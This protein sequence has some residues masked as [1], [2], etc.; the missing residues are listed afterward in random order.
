MNVN[1]NLDIA[2]LKAEFKEKKLVR[3]DNFLSIETA[4]DAYLFYNSQM[5]DDWWYLSTFPLRPGVNQVTDNVR[6]MQDKD[7]RS[8]NS[9]KKALADEYFQEDLYSYSFKRTIGDHDGACDCFECGFRKFLDSLEVINVIN[10]ITDYGIIEA[11]T[12]FA[13]KYEE[14]DFL[15]PHHDGPN[16]KIGFVYNLTPGWRPEWGGLLNTLSR[17]KMTILDSLVPKYN[18]LTLFDSST[19][20]GYPHYVTQVVRK[21]VK[22]LSY[23]GWYR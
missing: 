4:K 6:E 10:D 5:P 18:T 1:P 14:G 21:N 8:I 19:D 20:T 16:G 23:T 12:L 22:R 17:D 13:S 11:G 3:I 7:I 2:A 9:Y 15:A